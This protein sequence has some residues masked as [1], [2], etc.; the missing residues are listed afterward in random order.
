ML[1]HTKR[2]PARHR[3][4]LS[5]SNVTVIRGAV[6]V[7]NQLDL[8]I[9]PTSRIA[10]V[11]ENGRG[12][13]TLLHVLTGRLTPEAGTV[14]LVGTI[15]VADQEMPADDER[16]VGQAIAESIAEPLAALR[17]L[18]QAAEE[19]SHTVIGAEERYAT[20]LE[21]AE[22]LDAWN[23]ERRVQ[24]ALEA[25]D[26]E[27]NQDRLLR[28]LSVGQRYRVRL[29]C[30]LGSND[31]FL[32]LDEPTNHLDRSGLNF[33][34]TQLQSRPGGVVVVTHDRALLADVAETIVDLDPTHDDR[35]RIYGNG[36]TG[37]RDGRT[38]ERERWEQE[39]A[40][41][42][43]EHLRLQN[44]LSSA[45]NRLIS[46]WRPEKGTN[47]HGRATRAGGLVQSIHRRQEMLEEHAITIPE[48]PLQ[49]SCPQLP[50]KKGTPLLTVESLSSRARLAK[51]VSFTLTQGGRLA[52]T[53]PNGSGK[54]TLL[55]MIAGSLE[56]DNG[57]VA[58]RRGARL[59]FLKQE[60]HLPLSQRVSDVFSQYVGKLVA[61]GVLAESETINL[62][63]LGLLRQSESNKHVGELSMGQQR[64]L[65]LALV[66]ASKPHLLLLDEP[67]NHLSIAL[68][69]ELTEA[70]ESTHAA[71]ILSTHDRQL[72]RDVQDWP[73]LR[74]DEMTEKEVQA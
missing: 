32:L 73:S 58:L 9:T 63:Q 8:T 6:R 3:A 46:G 16:T 49:F 54:S 67:T 70:L 19:L 5:I 39:Y 44:S 14:K 25:L 12:K 11:G 35:I 28:D 29:A 51:P 36:Y 42:Q 1:T 22:Q 7:L 68:V 34:S 62:S 24:I 55:R 64:R 61:S 43:A 74:L 37:Y 53:G 48:P 65:D 17:A 31:D 69:D 47:K 4:Q 41:Q 26:A 45:Q 23:A 13:S 71:V 10:I 21:S 59:G 27:T 60:S 57:S 30:L 56:P 66:L 2:V 40:R 18:S 20:A 38:A 15:G 33:L 52:V 50:G 72:L